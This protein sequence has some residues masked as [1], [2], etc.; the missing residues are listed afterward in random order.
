MTNDQIVA[1]CDMYTKKLD[2]MG[3]SAARNREAGTREERLSHANWMCGEILK[4]TAES[5]VPAMNRKALMDA[6]QAYLDHDYSDTAIGRERLRAAYVDVR[7][8][9]RS[10][11]SF[12]REKAM[13]WLGH[14][15]G[16][17][18]EHG[19]YTIDQMADHNRS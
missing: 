1:I 11:A 3:C 8:D 4:F 17:L 10:G 7:N 13:R 12:R 6:V 16:I 15:Q 9:D 19:V 14:V 5:V 2:G 18:S